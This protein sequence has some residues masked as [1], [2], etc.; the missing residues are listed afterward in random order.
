M[1]QLIA[2]ENIPLEAVDL[3]KKGGIDIVTL[4]ELLRGISD[5]SLLV[6]A[7]AKNRILVTFDRDFGQLVF[8][9]KLETHGIMLLLFVPKSPQQI[10]KC[11]QHVLS[12]KVTMTN[13]V[14][15]V[16][17]DRIKVTRAK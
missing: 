5:R 4:P 11:I 7:K 2:D 14:V 9:E 6:T 10:A 8:K 3:L 12:T 13:M 17:E 15:T 1:T 16:R